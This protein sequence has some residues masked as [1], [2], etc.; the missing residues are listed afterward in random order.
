MDGRCRLAASNG[1]GGSGDDE[2][3]SDAGEG[4][5]VCRTGGSDEMRANA[6]LRKCLLEK[7]DYCQREATPLCEDLLNWAGRR[8][9]DKRRGGVGGL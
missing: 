2:I 3:L 6:S 8:G 5:V 4:G 7:S 1:L 9:V